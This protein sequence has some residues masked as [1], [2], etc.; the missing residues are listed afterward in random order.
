MYICTWWN[1]MYIMKRGC[2]SYTVISLVSAKRGYC[3]H[4]LGFHQLYA[5]FLTTC[6]CGSWPYIMLFF[7]SMVSL[8]SWLLSLMSVCEGGR[9]LEVYYWRNNY[10]QN[11]LENNFI[12]SESCLPRTMLPPDRF[13]NGGI[14]ITITSRSQLWQ[15]YGHPLCNIYM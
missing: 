9:K 2:G 11:I 13:S 1:H 8:S 3:L 14:A 4:D 12:G 6:C 15:L 10:L 5:G 7:I